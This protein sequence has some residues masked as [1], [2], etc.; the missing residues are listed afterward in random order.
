VRVRTLGEILVRTP[1]QFET[2]IC[3]LLRQQGYRHVHCVGGPGDLNADI[4]G[5]DPQGRSVVPCTCYTPGNRI[6]SRT[7]QTFIGM[8]Y[9]H[10]KADRAIFVTWSTCTDDARALGGQHGI[11]LIE[12]AD[13]VRMV[14][15][16]KRGRAA[17]LKATPT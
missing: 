2:F 12:G 3:E 16:T 7:M 10:H 8:A 17:T 15:E 6:G 13:L 4:T 9:I 11:A 1:S 5:M 14:D